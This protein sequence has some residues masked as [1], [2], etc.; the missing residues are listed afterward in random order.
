LWAFD[1]KESR[2]VSKPR[3]AICKE[4]PYRIKA[5]NTCRECGCFLPAK[6]RLTDEACPL[7][8]W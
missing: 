8:R 1:T 6:T 2:E 7:L 4:C 3:M 5:T